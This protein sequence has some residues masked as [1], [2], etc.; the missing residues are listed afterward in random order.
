MPRTLN[1]SSQE[2]EAATSKVWGHCDLQRVRWA[3]LLNETL[4]P[5][6]G[7]IK[8]S[9]YS[10]RNYQLLNTVRRER[11]LKIENTH[12]FSMKTKKK[13]LSLKNAKRQENLV[14]V[15][16]LVFNFFDVSSWSWNSLVFWH[17]WRLPT[18]QQLKSKRDL[19]RDLPAQPNN[20]CVTG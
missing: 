11:K 1:P 15:V 3:G 8:L 13:S 17:S 10:L 20:P 2:A 12:S 14:V 7:N 18:R 16:L 4:S 19:I 9:S 6:E 5:R